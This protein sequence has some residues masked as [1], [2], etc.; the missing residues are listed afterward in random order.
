[1]AIVAVIIGVVYL[2]LGTE[3]FTNIN[4]YVGDR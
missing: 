3:T 4:N 1:M 2:Q